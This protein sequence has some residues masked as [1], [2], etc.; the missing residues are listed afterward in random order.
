MFTDSHDDL[1]ANLFLSILMLAMICGGNIELVRLKKHE[2]ASIIWYI[3]TFFFLLF[4][5]AG[6]FANHHGQSLFQLC[7]SYEQSC[8][9]ISSYLTNVEDEILLLFSVTALAI[10]PQLLTYFLTG[11][12][13]IAAAPKLI[14]Q[15]Q[16][17]AMWSWIKFA[18]GMGGIVAAKPMADL[19]SGKPANMGDIAGAF[20]MTNYSF[21]SAC[22]FTYW[23]TETLPWLQNAFSRAEDD[24]DPLTWCLFKVQRFFTRHLR[25][26][27]TN[28]SR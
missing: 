22:V 24:M 9:I 10:A 8:K 18:A 11:L 3:N 13:G 16:S 25:S 26:K 17:I 21:A 14:I 1:L 27:D 19:V 28:A 15:I 23:K 7:G 4:W 20:A 2:E 6:V 5:G 12:F